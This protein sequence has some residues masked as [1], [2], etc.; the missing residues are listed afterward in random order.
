MGAA[1]ASVCMLVSVLSMLVVMIMSS[2]AVV[3]SCCQG[4]IEPS[5]DQGRRFE[6]GG[7][8]KDGHF[9][10]CKTLQCAPADSAGNQQLYPFLFQPVGPATWLAFWRDHGSCAHDPLV[11]RIHLKNASEL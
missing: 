5:L 3:H 9:C 8:H 6:N 2:L 11:L 7:S 1:T 10:V 4:T